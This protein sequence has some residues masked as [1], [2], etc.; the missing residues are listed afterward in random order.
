MVGVFTLWPRQHDNRV[1]AE[2]FVEASSGT[3]TTHG[4]VGSHRVVFAVEVGVELCLL[5]EVA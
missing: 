1:A 3:A 2:V 5:V 4:L